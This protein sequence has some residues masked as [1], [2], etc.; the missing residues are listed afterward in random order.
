MTLFLA[1]G[2]A[3]WLGVLTS[4]SPCPLA[5][6]IAAISFI[7]RGAGHPR[8]VL[9]AGLCYTLGRMLSYVALGALVVGGLLSVPA[10]S[11]FLQQYMNQLLGPVLVL[12]GMALLEMLPLRLPGIS[13]GGRLQALAD[14]GGLGAVLL[15]AVLALS[16]CPVSAALFFGSLVGLSLVHRSAVLLPSVYGVGTALPVVAFAVLVAMGAEAV[17]RAWAGLSAL[18]KYA[19][20]ATGIVFIVVGVFYSLRYIFEVPVLG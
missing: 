9:L 5:G 10:A 13:A 2:T 14:R 4:I 18:E 15:G 20:R 7:G 8:Q 3:L 19:R 17:A 16:F 6:N 12:T 11:R 1:A